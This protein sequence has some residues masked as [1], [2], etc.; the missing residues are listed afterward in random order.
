[1]CFAK[2]KD[3]NKSRHIVADTDTEIASN[4]VK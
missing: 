3:F 1:M 2:K 4:N